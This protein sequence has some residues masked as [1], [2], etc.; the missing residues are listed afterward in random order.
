MD[1]KKVIETARQ[2]HDG[3]F[4][5]WGNQDPYIVHPI[6]VAEKLATL[7][8]VEQDDIA[9]AYLHDVIEDVA[10]KQNKVAEYETLI[11]EVASET[12]LQLVWELTNPTEGP[13][14]EGKP[15]VQKRKADWEHIAK[16]SSRAKRIKLVDRW[17]NLQNAKVMPRKLLAKYV[18]ESEVL[19]ELCKEADPEMARQLQERIEMAKKLVN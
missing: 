2:A 1:M 4:R 18:G 12:T 7:V 13:E 8:G 6:R 14:W 19:L 15:R 11:R 5:K 16:I 17:D 9:A 10:I 3:Q